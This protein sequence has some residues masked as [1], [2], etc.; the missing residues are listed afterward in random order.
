[1]QLTRQLK[2]AKTEQ[3][4]RLAHEA[5]IVYSQTLVYYR[6]ILRKKSIFLSKS[7]MQKLVRNK[8]LHSQT[9]QGITD[10]F[11]DNLASY[12]KLHKT[13][14]Q[15]RLPKRR[16]WYFVL[17]Y[18]SSAIRLQDN[19]LI[20]S[21][22]KSNAPLV[23]DWTFD[24]PDFVRISFDG[25]KYVINAVYDIAVNNTQKDGLTAGIDLGEIHLAVANIGEKTIIINGRALR[26]KRRYQNKVKGKF[27]QRL[28]EHKK[29]SRKYKQLNHKKKQV[30]KRLDNQIKDILHKQTTKLVQTLKSNDVC[31][32]AIGDVR[33]IR[34]NVDYTKKANQKIHQMPTGQVRAMIE[35]KC[36]LYGINTVVINEA[37]STRTC[38]KCLKRNAKPKDRNYRCKFCGFEYHRDGVGAINIRQKQMYREYA[39]VVGVMTPP[40]GIRYVV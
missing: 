12:W 9:V 32:V 38:P 40:I 25:K 18:K 15:A 24:K 7:S 14:K 16:K 29:G 39:P 4:D 17:P 34:K 2:I 35:Y 3:L 13:D 23:L 37:Y 10:I 19:K 11:Y 27:Q 20:L 26:S 33:D 30:L 36:E 1:M 28:S 22:G 5:G 31:T 6:R 8:S 21:N